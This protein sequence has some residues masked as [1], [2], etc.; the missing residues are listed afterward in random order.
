MQLV[1]SAVGA[2]EAALLP[3]VSLV[4]SR[5]SG[6]LDGGIKCATA[7]CGLR[8]LL[9]E[10]PAGNSANFCPPASGLSALRGPWLGHSSSSPWTLG[11][12]PTPRVHISQDYGS[13]IQDTQAAF[14]RLFPV[15][16][17]DCWPIHVDSLQPF[18]YLSTCLFS[19]SFSASSE[20]SPPSGS[21]PTLFLSWVLLMDGG[22]QVG[23]ML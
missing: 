3:T 22:R 16:C 4:H 8:G 11:P 20:V 14:I 10:L 1:R 5:S 21:S 2:Q 18:W 23:R 15:C 19:S 7:V 6:Q 9:C 12:P 13:D 17:P